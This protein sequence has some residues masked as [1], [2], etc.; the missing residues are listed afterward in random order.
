MQSLDFFDASI[1]S[2]SKMTN[3]AFLRLARKRSRVARCFV[4]ETKKFNFGKFWMALN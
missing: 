4:F 2:R 1:G 3:C